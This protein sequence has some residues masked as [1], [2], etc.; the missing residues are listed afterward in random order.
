MESAWS[1]RV[2]APRGHVELLWNQ[3]EV[4]AVSRVDMDA[5]AIRSRSARISSAGRRLLWR[6]SPE[7]RLP[8]RRRL[9]EARLRARQGPCARGCRLATVRLQLQHGRNAAGGCS[10]PG[11]TRESRL[12]GA[13]CPAIQSASR[14]AMV[15]LEV[16]C[17]EVTRRGPA[18]HGGD[19]RDGLHLHLRAGAAAI[20]GMIVRVDSHGQRVSGAGNGMRRLEHLPGIQRVEIGIVVAQPERRLPESAAIAAIRAGATGPGASGRDWNSASSTSV[21]RAS[22]EGTGSELV[23]A[24]CFTVCTGGERSG[25]RKIVMRLRHFGKSGNFL[26][27][28]RIGYDYCRGDATICPALE[29]NRA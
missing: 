17:P 6:W 7:W 3:S 19:L 26:E 16:R 28:T 20:P 22:S 14:L 9:C 27:S 13:I 8:C 2:S 10:A 18:E 15:P 4:A 1:G 29:S 23:M 11:Q 12:P 24:Q 5:E 21:A 25:M